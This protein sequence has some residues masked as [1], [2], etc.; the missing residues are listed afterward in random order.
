MSRDPTLAPKALPEDRVLDVTLRPKKWQDYIGQEKVKRSLQIMLG[1]AKLRKELPEHL[2]FHGSA[3]LGKTTLSYLI[4]HE[5]QANIRITSGPAIERAGDLAAIL[6]NLAEGDILFID[7]CHRL[8]KQVEEYLYPALEE[9]KLHLI[10]GHGPMARTMELDLPRFTLIA[11]TTRPALLSAPLRSRFGAIFRLD[12]YDNKEIA[13][14]LRRSADLLKIGVD[15]K[16]LELI[17]QRSRFTPRVANRLLKRVRDFAQVEGQD[18]RSEQIAD[19]ALE[20]MEIDQHGLEPSDRQVLQT[21]IEKFDGGPT[22]LQAL[23]AA[24]SQEQDTILEV[25]EPYLL[26]LGF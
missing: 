9:F 6:T 8:S 15:E 23:A 3:G 19:A 10:L 5:L 1:A 7:E 25:S 21:L 12:Y 22:G 11:A 24:S 18:T 13:A 26:R 17:A 20:F 16:A 2:L 14:I 4:A